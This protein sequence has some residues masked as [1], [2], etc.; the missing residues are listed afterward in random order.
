MLALL[1]SRRLSITRAGVAHGAVIVQFR[2]RAPGMRSAGL[3]LNLAAPSL[4]LG[5]CLLNHL[6]SLLE[7][8]APSLF[9]FSLSLVIYCGLAFK[10]KSRNAWVAQRLGACLQLRA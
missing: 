5:S 2:E 1:V 7:S 4:V 6:N 10:M 8:V 3:G 9:F